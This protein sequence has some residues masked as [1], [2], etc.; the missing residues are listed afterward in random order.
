M[1]TQKTIIMPLL[2]IIHYNL[3]LLFQF[4]SKARGDH[5]NDVK[6]KFLYVSS[7]THQSDILHITGNSVKGALVPFD[8]RVLNF[9]LVGTV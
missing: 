6:T 8:P 5:G 2:T 1:D 4:Q 7:K 9:F 3:Y